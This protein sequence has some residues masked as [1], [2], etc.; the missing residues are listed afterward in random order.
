MKA[1]IFFHYDSKTK[2]TNL[3][4]KK[5]SILE[6]PLLYFLA[7]MPNRTFIVRDSRSMDI[8]QVG[9]KEVQPSPN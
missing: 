8:G 5:N 3:K 2:Q 9:Q 6:L 4:K 7:T 1:S